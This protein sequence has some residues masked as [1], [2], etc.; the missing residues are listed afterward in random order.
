MVA[1]VVRSSQGWATFL[2]RFVVDDFLPF[3]SHI[4]V[5]KEVTAPLFVFQ[6]AFYTP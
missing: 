1:H 4:L 6:A 5:S 3:G 2:T